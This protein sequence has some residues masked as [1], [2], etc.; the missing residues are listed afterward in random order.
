MWAP[1]GLLLLLGRHAGADP[2]ITPDP[3]APSKVRVSG[4]GHFGPSWDLD[5][6]YVWLGPTGTASH[7]D[8]NWDT[9]WGGAL[10]VLRVRE[11]AGLAIDGGSLGAARWTER[12]AGRIWAD[13]VVGTEVGDH[14]AIGATLGPILELDAHVPPR[15]GGSVGIWGF[16]GVTPFA[17]VGW[18]DGLGTFAEV[19]LHIALPV[20]RRAASQSGAKW[21]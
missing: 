19:G 3:P 8:G 2:G 4:P 14:H 18:V 5:G 1:L 15:L 17:R 6:L 9:T 20:Y 21:D 16:A 10:S 12:D 7:V 11:D 13:F